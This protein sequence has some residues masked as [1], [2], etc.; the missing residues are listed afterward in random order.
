MGRQVAQWWTIPSWSFD[1]KKTFF[2]LGVGAHTITIPRRVVSFI[3]DADLSEFFWPKDS[4]NQNVKISL[5]V[6]NSEAGKVTVCDAEIRYTN[7]AED[8]KYL[9]YW[10]RYPETKEAIQRCFKKEY[11]KVKNGKP[12]APIRGTICHIAGRKFA[13]FRT[14]EDD[15]D[16]N[17]IPTKIA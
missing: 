15:D 14:D 16:I 2:G 9:M 10:D 6:I 11:N 7:R 3:Q 1:P 8:Q 17:S 5:H 12:A 4:N 13:L